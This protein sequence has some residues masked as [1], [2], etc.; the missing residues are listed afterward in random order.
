M[1]PI[2]SVSNANPRFPNV[3]KTRG[4]QIRNGDCRVKPLV[5][6]Q[7]FP[8]SR[9]STYLNAASVAL[10]YQDAARALIEWQED[11]AEYG[12]I[13]FDEVAEEAI[14]DAL[15]KATAQLL[16]VQPQDIAVGSSATELISSLAW[17]VAPGPETNVISTDI[18]FPSTLYPWARVSRRTNCEIRLAKGHHGYANP[19]EMIQLIDR[20]T[21]VV[22]ISHVE[23]G[24]G[25]KYD[26]S[27]L[28]DAAHEVG[29]LLVVDATQSAGMLPIDARSSNVDVLVTGAYKWLCGPFGVALMYLSPPLQKTLDPGLVGWR[30]HQDMWDHQADRLEFPDTA[31]RFEFS[32]MAYGCV[33]GLTRSIE[34]L[35]QVGIDQIFTYTRHLADSLREGLEARGFITVSPESDE[36]RTAILAGRF[37]GKDEADVVRYLNEHQVVASKRKEYIRFSPHLYNTSD[38]ISRTL[39]LIERMP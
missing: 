37:P 8:A 12:T 38:D 10:M 13:N 15:R 9:K 32:T 18:V 6:P 16:H 1:H 20:N 4:L 11:L 26:L 28:A 31:Q 33:L 27:G 35:L 22:C 24:T 19:Y 17:A 3:L 29:A 7:D 39:E 23:F 30:S 5:D 14:F 25:Q 34:Y 2:T 36:E 21:A